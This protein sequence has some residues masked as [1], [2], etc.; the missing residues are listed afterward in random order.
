MDWTAFVAR[1]HWL[2]LRWCHE[3][4]RHRTCCRHAPSNPS[5]VRPLSD[6]DN[7][8]TSR[9]R[10]LVF[11]PRNPD[12]Y[13]RQPTP[14]IFTSRFLFTRMLP[15][16]FLQIF[17][18]SLFIGSFSYVFFVT[19]KCIWLNTERRFYLMKIYIG[20]RVYWNSGQVEFGHWKR[21]F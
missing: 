8:P 2:A 6:D 10:L 5:D 11:A 12:C 4:W 1:F 9:R 3:R 7:H 17:F 13:L 21:L 16:Y 18:F 15:T 14:T 20:T 19:R